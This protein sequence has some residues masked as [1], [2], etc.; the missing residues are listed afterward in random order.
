MVERAER[1]DPAAED[2]AEDER[3]REE[4]DAPEQPAVDRVRREHGHRAD[5]RIGEQERLD[6]ERQAHRRVRLRG[7]AAAEARLEEEVHEED[8]EA[9]LRRATHPHEDADALP[10]GDA[11]AGELRIELLLLGRDRR[12]A[13]RVS[14]RPSSR[15]SAARS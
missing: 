2:A 15:V 8:E 9:D 11:G 5:E 3:E 14:D 10:R 12:D 7:E 4:A 6:R 1:A 13:E